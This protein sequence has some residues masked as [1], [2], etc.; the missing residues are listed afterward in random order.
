LLQQALLK[1]TMEEML[2]ILH[3]IMELVVEVE[4]V[5][6]VPMVLHQLVE[7]GVDVHELRDDAKDRDFYIDAPV[8]EKSLCLHAKVLIF[9]Q[10]GNRI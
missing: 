7:M 6:L 1:E 10:A 8:S 5:E 4:L 3:L 2:L 9:D